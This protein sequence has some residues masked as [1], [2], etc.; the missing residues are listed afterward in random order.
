MLPTA[1][2]PRQ[3][4]SLL[5]LRRNTVVRTD[6]LI[7]EL[8]EESP[9]M[10]A[11][12]TLQTYIYKLR[13]IL[14]G[15]GAEELLS[16][17]PGGYLLAIPD[18]SID[19]YRFEQDATLGQAALEGGDAAGAAETLRRALGLWRGQALADVV[20]GGLLS[21]YATR[22]E[23]LRSRALELRLEADL[24]LGRHRELIS[25]LRS[26]VLTHP[27][28]EHLHAALMIALHRS[29]RRHEALEV[30][31]VLRENMIEN[32]GLDPGRE[33]REL[34][35]ALLADAP[36]GGPYEQERVTVVAQATADVVA[37]PVRLA[38][39]AVL[40]GAF[41]NGNGHGYGHPNGEGHTNGHA[42][43]N[44]D[45]NGD[46]HANGSGVGVVA[47]A[48]DIAGSF[49]RPEPL[50]VPA[51][52]PG[53][54]EPEPLGLVI[55]PLGPPAQ[56]PADIADFTGRTEIVEEVLAGLASAGAVRNWTATP[57]VTVSG[58]PG[59]GKTALAIHLAHRLRPRFTDGQLYAD[60]RGSV[61]GSRD[62]PEVLGGFLQAMG[63]PEAHIPFGLEERSTLFRSVTAGRRLLIV[64]DDAPSSAYVRPL[65]PGDPGCTLIV[66]SRR[67]LHGL[68]GNW[69][70]DLD[71]M[72]HA[73]GVE[74]L[75]RVVGR[76]RLDRAPSA[77]DRLV[78]LG[79]RLP[80]ALRCIGSRL[81]TMPDVSITE[82]AERLAET[83][84]SLDLLSVGELD[85]RA[86]YDSSYGALS[87]REQ[88]VFRLLSMLPSP[89]F[90]AREAAELLGWDAA[91]I[92]PALEGLVDHRLIRAAQGEDGQI[93]YRFPELVLSYARERLN[94]ALD[95]GPSRAS[96]EHP[97]PTG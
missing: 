34:H 81:A 57:V 83:P 80:L 97:V 66:T 62:L 33:L 13:K 35:Q 53:D 69:D 58:T 42:K 95:P 86:R 12:T 8:W 26:L 30:Y 7:D 71:V 59:V 37:R 28:H 51:E 61:D 68:A 88:A 40:P 14:A 27:L 77:A 18:H 48:P 21:S 32:L 56:L 36:F 2:K 74:L 92:R 72:D 17:R 64:L 79:G 65:I 84:R 85:L 31:R 47:A 6:E 50:A 75:G 41:L 5:L 60:L 39:E 22:L 78:E 25:E 73:E 20:Q 89:R 63:V 54:A 96:R 70:V 52:P 44:G 93:R 29:G 15:L 3:V 24:Q 43:A 23:E 45:R 10:S 1:S 38:D 76:A 91:D 49:V 19:L 11:M 82:M 4:I 9:P 67:R 46:G 87:R 94:E 16:T 90:T 55:P